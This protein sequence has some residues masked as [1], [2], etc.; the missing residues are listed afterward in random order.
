MCGTLLNKNCI[1]KSWNREGQE[2]K[3]SVVKGQ[4]VDLNIRDP[5]KIF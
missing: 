2:V 5:L 4:V 1:T 3:L